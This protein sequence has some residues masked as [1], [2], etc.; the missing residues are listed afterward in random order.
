MLT[1]TRWVANHERCRKQLTVR[2]TWQKEFLA[3][4]I[5]SALVS[6]GYVWLSWYGFD[7]LEEGY[8]ATHARR[9]Q[10]GGLPYRDFST[11]Y[12]PGIFYLGARLMDWF[13]TDVVVLRLPQIIS[14]VVLTLALYSAGRHLMPPFFAALPP[15]LILI[16]DPVPHRWSL[17]PGWVTT[18]TTALGVLAI[19]RY[20]QTGLGRWLLVSGLA[21]GVG[22]A[23]KQNLAAYG[24]MA[25]LWLV[26]VAE[27]HL[28]PVPAPRLWRLLSSLRFIL[29]AANNILPSQQS[30]GHGRRLGRADASGALAETARSRTASVASGLRI[31]V[32]LA[33]LVFLPLT[34]GVLVRSYFSTVVA[35][36]LVLPLAAVSWAAA[37]GV[38][39][40]GH[41]TVGNACP[42]RVVLTREASFYVRPLF[43]MIGFSAVTIPWLVLLIKALQGNV[44]LLTGFVG[45]VDLTAYVLPMPRLRMTDRVLLVAAVLP[46]LLM[47]MRYGS[48]LWKRRGATLGLCVCG[49]LL[50]VYVI[51]S[52]SLRRNRAV[53]LGVWGA[54]GPAWSPYAG[55]GG[56]HSGVL[57][58][59]L[60]TLAF[61]AA[62][63]KLLLTLRKEQTTLTG[64]TVLRLW[65]LTAG[66]ALLLNQYPRMDAA[67]MVW[68]GGVLLVVGADLLHVWYQFL[69]RQ[70][71]TIRWAGRS[72]VKL[73][74]V[75][76][77]IMAAVPQASDRLHG[78]SL[79]AMSQVASISPSRL[80]PVQRYLQLTPAGAGAFVWAPADQARP[81]QEVVDFLRQ[82][83]ASG[84]PIFTYPSIPGFYF[85]ADRPNA[86]RFN[87]LFGG[88]T[89]RRDQEEMVAQLEAVR[90]I[91]WDDRGA[92]IWVGPGDNVRLT[93]Y[94]HAHFRVEREMGIYTI[95][96][97]HAAGPS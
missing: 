31:A 83:T 93:E 19:A 42:G 71:P 1:L 66:S 48:S 17:H 77:P 76:L 97:R 38:A 51:D 63:A 96:S 32:Q 22:F 33:A 21:S 28:P 82:H 59:Y 92:D 87:H 49:G 44:A 41:A 75:L 62:F 74:V 18:A 27:R 46:P 95:L 69:L 30:E 4:G 25:G 67:H 80:G 60:P 45:D 5:A 81:I 6:I 16:L 34:A 72:V 10:L 12:T 54:A 24:L 73:S 55:T 39:F 23:F 61:W 26:I 79:F 8:F 94:I 7:L 50:A 70:L 90:Y 29:P 56:E 89:S 40:R 3:A 11:P 58:L 36:L 84:E 13:G 14:R 88:M 9:V 35:G 52:L 78:L 20:M 43:L 15:A 2:L 85:L 64:G 86:T 57:F 68:S 65:Y 53:D 47:L 91:V 37:T